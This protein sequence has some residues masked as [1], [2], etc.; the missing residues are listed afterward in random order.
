M[1]KR[2][3]EQIGPIPVLENGITGDVVIHDRLQVNGYE[4]YISK[5]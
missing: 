5:D 1:K 2:D 4:S 3:W